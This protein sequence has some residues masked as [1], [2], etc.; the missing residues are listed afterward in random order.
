MQYKFSVNQKVKIIFPSSHPC[1]NKI[2]KIIKIDEKKF[3]MFYSVE[4]DN[5]KKYFFAE[6]ELENV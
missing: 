5:G 6:R 1:I 3:I 4:F 2:G